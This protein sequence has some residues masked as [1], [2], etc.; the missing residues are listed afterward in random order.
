M[1]GIKANAVSSSRILTSGL[2]FLMR[3]PLTTFILLSASRR[4]VASQAPSLRRSQRFGLKPDAGR[5]LVG[6]A[7]HLLLNALEPDLRF[8]L[9]AGAAVGV[10]QPD[11]EPAAWMRAE[12]RSEERRVGKE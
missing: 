2:Q 11:H 6:R 8:F 3:S 9:I 10:R 12:I 1:G 7:L 4:S 5:F